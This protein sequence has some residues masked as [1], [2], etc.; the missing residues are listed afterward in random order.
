ME[1]VNIEQKIKEIFLSM[2]PNEDDSTFKMEKQQ[3]EFENWDSFAHLRLVSE[4]EKQ[5]E[6]ELDIDEVIYL[7]SPK[8]FLNLISTKKTK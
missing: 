4:M 7:N 8:D 2:F 5:F 3:L 1:T 6:L